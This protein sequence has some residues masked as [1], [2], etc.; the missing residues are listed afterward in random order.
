MKH[1]LHYSLNNRK[2]RSSPVYEDVR[3]CKGVKEGNNLGLSRW[4]PVG[5]Q[6]NSKP[7]FFFFFVWRRRWGR[8]EGE[9]K[10]TEG[11]AIQSRLGAEWE[12]LFLLCL[13]HS[14]EYKTL[15]QYHQHVLLVQGLLFRAHTLHSQHNTPHTTNTKTSSC[16]L[17][18][19]FRL[20]SVH[21]YLVHLYIHLPKQPYF[22]IF[23]YFSFP[24]FTIFLLEKSHSPGCICIHS[25]KILT[26]PSY[27]CYGQRMTPR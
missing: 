8:S 9:N 24:S 17:A 7:F 2:V 3:L 25:K 26:L 10:V 21:L 5:K 15:I 22:T 11:K 16:H 1:F 6:K 4:F 12:K 23:S 18:H 20:S 13:H 14:L 27:S 19:V